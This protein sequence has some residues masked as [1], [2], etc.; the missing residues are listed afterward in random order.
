MYTLP[1]NDELLNKLQQE[2]VFTKLDFKLVYH[3][4]S[5]KVEDLWKK[6]FERETHTCG[7]SNRNLKEES[8]HFQFA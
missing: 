7:T 5:V 3:Q 8:N 6:M 1:K 4:M 2:N